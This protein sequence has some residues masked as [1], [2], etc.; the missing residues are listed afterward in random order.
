MEYKLFILVKDLHV[1]RVAV[2]KL[3]AGGVNAIL[4]DY[5][6]YNIKPPRTNWGVMVDS[7]M[8]EQA[9]ML[10]AQYLEDYS[11]N[12]V[13]DSVPV[14]VSHV[15]DSNGTFIST[16]K[17][18]AYT[19]TS[20]YDSD[21]YKQESSSKNAWYY[22]KRIAFVILIFVCCFVY[23]KSRIE[24]DNQYKK[25]AAMRGELMS[26]QNNM[27]KMT[28]RYQ[29]R[30]S[31]RVNADDTIGDAELEG[32]N[33][34]TLTK[35]I[36]DVRDK[37]NSAPIELPNGFKIVGVSMKGTQIKFDLELISGTAIS[38][39]QNGE[40]VP[41]ELKSVMT[42]TV[43]KYLRDEIKKKKKI[44]GST[45]L[46]QLADLQVSYDFALFN[47]GA[48]VPLFNTS[49]TAQQLLDAESQEKLVVGHQIP[50]FRHLCD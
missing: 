37:I 21:D 7:Q 45:Y 46:Q 23:I 9:K 19:S 43:V 14:N 49:F 30:N 33:I 20:S 1:A 27:L 44:Y 6:D 11:I 31:I 15:N 24:M 26:Y 12:V 10:L 16:D 40:L 42:K 2:E 8:T 41:E 39:S 18:P 38:Y 47:S 50:I 3:E 22:L 48:K 29:N 5:C 13:D 25:Q 4:E 36:D 34:L 28:E 35:V 17:T 32:T